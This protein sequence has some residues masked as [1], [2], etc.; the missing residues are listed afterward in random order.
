MK[1]SKILYTGGV[2]ML[3][4][5][6]PMLFNNGVYWDDWVLY[7][8]SFEQ[9]KSHF[10]GNGIWH[11]TYMHNF[12]LTIG[13][14]YSPLL[15]HILSFFLFYLGFV[16]LTL[17]IRS[18]NIRNKNLLYVASLGILVL[19]FFDAKTTMICFPYTIHTTLFLAATYLLLISIQTK[20]VGLRIFSLVLFFFSF[21]VQSLVV[22]Y[23][24]PLL[25][26]VFFS[27]FKTDHTNYLSISYYFSKI[28]SQ[29]DF[30]FLPVLFFVYKHFFLQ[31][32]GLYAEIGYNEITLIGLLKAPF[33]TLIFI[34]YQFYGILI[35]IKEKVFSDLFGV[36][37]FLCLGF[38]L[39]IVIKKFFRLNISVLENREKLF[40]FLTGFILLF[41][42]IFPYAV[43]GKMPSFMGYA[44]R[45][46]VLIPFGFSLIVVVLCTV[47]IKRNNVSYLLLSIIISIFITTTFLQQVQ[48]IKGWLKQESIASSLDHISFDDTPSTVLVQDNTEYLDATERDLSFYSW[49]GILKLNKEKEHFF[50]IEVDEFYKRKPL[51]PNILS[52]KSRFNMTNYNLKDP[53]GILTINGGDQPLTSANSFR[54]VYLYYLDIERFEKEIVTIL[55]FTEKNVE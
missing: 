35:E 27:E 10:Y 25:L 11:W 20:K 43:V 51:L 46:Q 31:P 7:N 52:E 42:A 22:F 55:S 37:F 44:T 13:G 26:V 36:V 5:Y 3:I 47:I 40:L 17:I 23:V 33:M 49:A 48:Y 9:L 6:F 21:H 39:F 41:L 14:E 12:L 50:W 8:S 32:S 34:A 19:P 1:L 16:F 54:Y 15:Y 29:L 24:F 18:L 53:E 45:H 2:L 28:K 4:S 38:I 30:F